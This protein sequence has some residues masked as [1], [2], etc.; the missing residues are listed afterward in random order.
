MYTNK[1]SIN[2]KKEIVNSDGKRVPDRCPKCGSEIGLFI[3]GEPVYLCKNKECNT[4]Y[5]TMPFNSKKTVNEGGYKRPKVNMNVELRKG[6]RNAVKMSIEDFK[7]EMTHAYKEYMMEND[8]DVSYRSNRKI[9][10]G[11]FLYQCCRGRKNNKN[12]ILSSL[13]SDVWDNKY[14]FD[15]E[16]L[17]SV[18]DIKMSSKGV[19]YIEASVGGD[20]ENPVC[21]FVYYDGHKFRGYVPLKGNAI[22]RDTKCAFGNDEEADEKFINK[23]LGVKSK[24]ES[25]YSSYDVDYDRNACLEDF[26][27]RIDVKGAYKK[28]DYTKDD[29]RYEDFKAKKEAERKK[30]DEEREMENENQVM[31]LNELQLR[32]IVKETIKNIL[33]EAFQSNKLRDYFKNHGGVKREYTKD[34]VGDINDKRVRQDGLGDVNDDDIVYFKAY[35]D[36]NDALHA[37]WELNHP[38][39]KRNRVND[40]Y[41]TVY[42]ANDNTAVVVGL[43]RSKVDIGITWGGEATKKTAD[44][45]MSNGWSH[46]TRNNRY[47]DDSDV[48]YTNRTSP[49]N[50]FGYHTSDDYKNKLSDL[51]RQKERYEE[52]PYQDALWNAKLFGSD[53]KKVEKNKENFLQKGREN[54]KRY[55]KQAADDAR[56]YIKRHYPSKIKYLKESL[57]EKWGMLSENIKRKGEESGA[58][59]KEIKRVLD[60]EFSHFL[61]ENG[62]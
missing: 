19:P 43:D 34:E 41:F 46:K 59:D 16:N 53:T 31:N 32:N 40:T 8:I 45:K 36:T 61:A 52:D 26:M 35:N 44:R 48:Y 37:A 38:K 22:N 13:N 57:F 1:T 21:F 42:K 29:E 7:T 28:H 20:W 25:G 49:V 10:A 50:D 55:R 15:S 39:E 33:S 24:E 12:G 4:Y 18:G 54:Y 3:K 9:G 47:V 2:K 6:G 27:S 5:G 58:D 23:E 60:K 11:S 14:K 17:D 56:E 51:E 62:I 30:R